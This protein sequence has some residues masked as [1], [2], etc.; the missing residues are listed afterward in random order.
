[1]PGAGRLGRG[2]RLVGRRAARGAGRVADRRTAVLRIVRGRGP[3]RR[4]GVGS[5]RCR[6]ADRVAAGGDPSGTAEGW[7]GGGCAAGH[8]TGTCRASGGDGRSA[9]VVR[10]LVVG[11]GVPRRVVPAAG[12]PVPPDGARARL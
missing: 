12:Q 4:P 9:V 2:G 5:C 3:G 7:W 10:P 11:V 8:R 1:R 6:S